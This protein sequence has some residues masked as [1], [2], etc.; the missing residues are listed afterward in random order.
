[1]K[2]LTIVLALL[3]FSTSLY[4]TDLRIED[5]KENR[6]TEANRYLSVMP[7]QDMLIDL[8]KKMSAQIP[9][10]KQ[11][12]FNDFM[13]KN[14]DLDRFSLI[15]RDSMVNHFTAEE[16]AALADFYG[17]AI[18]KS[19]MSKFGDYMAEAM[20]QLQTLMIEAAQKTK[21]QMKN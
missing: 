15:I 9:K 3:F 8:V 21:D 17:S 1:M 2:K 20:P 5:S 11:K 12:S 14:M 10:E 18:G 13:I 19:A 4:A 7:P 6:L 16:L